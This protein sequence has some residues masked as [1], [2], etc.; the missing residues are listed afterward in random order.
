[1]ASGSLKSLLTTFIK[2]AVSMRSVISLREG[3][4]GS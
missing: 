2:D 4:S 3:V 1:M